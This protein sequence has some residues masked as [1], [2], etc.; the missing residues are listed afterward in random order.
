MALQSTRQ[1]KTATESD[2]IGFFGKVPTHGD[3]I[4]EGLDRDLVT[5]IDEWLRSGLHACAEAFPGRWGD[6]FAASPPRRFIIERGV[7]GASAYAGVLLPNKDR[8]GRRY[9]FLLL[10][11]MSEFKQHPRALY[12]D[13]AWFIAVE[14]LLETSLRSDFDISRFTAAIKRLRMPRARDDDETHVS[15]G[16]RS[17]WWYIDAETRSARGLLFEGKLKS[18]DFLKIFEESKPSPQH[19]DEQ[20]EAAPAVA[21]TP[22]AAQPQSAPAVNPLVRDDDGPLVYSYATHPGTHLGVNAD[23]LFVSKAPALFAIADGVGEPNLGLE[24]ARLTT[25]SLTDILEDPS[26]ENLALR[27]KGKLSAVNSL[28]LHR[29][30]LNPTQRPMA[31]V[32]AASL[33]SDNLTVLWAGDAR[34]YLLRDGV[35]L[36]LTNDHVIVGMKRQLSQCV[37]IGQQFKP[38]VT[39]DNWKQGDRLLLCSFTLVNLLTERGVA[40][41]VAATPVKDCANA[42]I[43]EALIEN[44][45]DNVSAIVIGCRDDKRRR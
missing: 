32:V 27:I 14:A 25:N 35:M 42:L 21:I 19:P 40:E 36:P 39:V 29:P 43:Q 44:A 11:Q 12:L 16:R 15:E 24:A 20:N 26:A 41:V 34:A 17:F 5:L 7:W 4:S 13:D 22:Q 2:R 6:L 33:S 28:L 9:P 38:D 3:F 1:T 8:V 31:S 18:E 23:S 10:A 45:R 37:G 30:N